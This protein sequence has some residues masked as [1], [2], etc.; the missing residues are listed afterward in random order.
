MTVPHLGPRRQAL[1]DA[2]RDYASATPASEFHQFS[3]EN[4]HERVTRRLD[5]FLTEPTEDNFE[6]LWTP[7]VL[8]DA[9]IGGPALVLKNWGGSIDDL[10]ALFEEMQQAD[11]YDPDW[12]D[13]F[14]A[15]SVLWE[16]YGQMKPQ[17][18]PILS[19]AVL[20][21]LDAL[22]F[23][24]PKSYQDC[25]GYDR[26]A[27]AYDDIVGHATAGTDHEVPWHFEIEQFLAFVGTA[28][29]YDVH[30]EL[31][32]DQEYP[33]LVGWEAE[34]DAGRIV[35]KNL[36]PLLDKY[37]NSRAGGGFQQG[38]TGL[39]GDYWE[40][41]KWT[42][43]DHVQTTVKSQFE[44]PDL[45]ADD[46]EPFLKEFKKAPDVDLSS[47]VPTYM[48]GG[49]SGGI[50]WN[51]FKKTSLDDPEEAAHVLSTLFDEDQP[52]GERLGQFNDFYVDLSSGGPR[53]SLATM[54]LMFAYPDEYVMYKFGKFNAFFDAYSDYSV[55]TG[56][57]TE[58]YWVLNEACRRIRRRLDD[59][60][61]EDPRIEDDASMLDVHTLI[62][63]AV[64]VEDL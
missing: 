4:R 25:G 15:T 12:E 51:N 56:F 22:G 45:T 17:S 48:L 34:G 33:K 8:R 20:S 27:S 38:E 57:D 58:Q 62:W 11:A 60:F 40:S 23:K 31:S 1:L 55:S 21:G 63:V 16:L 32:L 54:L 50:L 14:V 39:W 52:L 44:L 59:A 43:A 61:E 5:E 9:V 18:R 47:S 35:F 7:D 36:D 26:F 10:A 41:W 64:G 46:V 2:W 29:Q 28:T 24:R 30:A 19:G 42:H 3:S 37:V 49:R 6:A 53:L 13:N